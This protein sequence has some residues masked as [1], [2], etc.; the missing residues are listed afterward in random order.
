M[1]NTDRSN[2]AKQDLTVDRLRTR[3][4]EITH[5]YGD[6]V[7]RMKLVVESP[8]EETIEY[9]TFVGSDGV[10][11]PITTRDCQ[12]MQMALMISDDIEFKRHRTR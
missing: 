12:D 11:S 3:G 8:A 9:Y 2:K 6:S 4:F 5:V 7:V 1:M 10:C